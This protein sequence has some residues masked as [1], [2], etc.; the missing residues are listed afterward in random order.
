MKGTRSI[1]D[2][3]YDQVENAYLDARIPR[4]VFR[5]YCRFWDWAYLRS[6]GVGFDQQWAWRRKFGL[7]VTMNRI[8]RCR[9]V[10]GLE[11]IQLPA[12]YEEQ[13]YLCS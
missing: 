2:K 8:N 9:R 3:P 5:Q 11:P 6:A 12:S 1:I 4:R 7:R 13:G 10:L